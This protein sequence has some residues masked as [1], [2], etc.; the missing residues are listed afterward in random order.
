MPREVFITIFIKGKIWKS[1]LG[2][3]INKNQDWK[4]NKKKLC[5]ILKYASLASGD[6]RYLLVSE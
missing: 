1:I 2:P 4:K 3:H 6:Y 5:L